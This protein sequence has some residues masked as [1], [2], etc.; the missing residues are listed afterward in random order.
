MASK[1][2][3]MFG[4]RNV[5]DG[6]LLFQESKS[7]VELVKD[8]VFIF[9]CILHQFLNSYFGEKLLGQSTDNTANMSITD[10]SIIMWIFSTVISGVEVMFTSQFPEQTS[11]YPTPGRRRREVAMRIQAA[12]LDAVYDTGWERRGDVVFSKRI[13][14]VAMRATRPVTISAWRMYYLRFSSFKEVT[15]GYPTSTP[16]GIS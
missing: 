6:F 3:N 4:M 14:L 8:V 16:S 5:Y 11:N 13:I 10:M 9:Y 15:P 1:C 2:R 12:T 7:G